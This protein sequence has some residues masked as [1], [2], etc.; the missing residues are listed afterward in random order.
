[1]ANLLPRPGGAAWQPSEL[2]ARTAVPVSTGARAS[3]GSA[4]ALSAGG[5]QSEKRLLHLVSIKWIHSILAGHR[6]E[7][8]IL[9]KISATLFILFSNNLQNT[10]KIKTKSA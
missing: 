7:F 4:L 1:L 3:P 9:I 6:R 5:S 10:E 8:P 2:P